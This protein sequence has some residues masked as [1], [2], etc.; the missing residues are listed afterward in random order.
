MKRNVMVILFVCLYAL[1]FPLT[2][3]AEE[4]KSEDKEKKD[5]FEIPSHVL[6]ISKENTYPNSTED[7]EVIEPSE[8]T[9][10][11]IEEMKVPIK[12]PDLIKMLNETTLKPSPIAIGY[13]G[14]VY[15]GRWPLNYESLETNINWEY[16]KINTNELNN[17]GGEQNQEMRYIQQDKK[18]IKGALTNKINN[19]D[20][21][22]KMMLLEA[23]DKTKL[24]LSYNTVI[25]K[26]TKK[27]NSYN[28][29]TEKY[30]TLQAYAPA[31]NEKG[32]V[33]FGEVYIEL[34]GGKKAIVIKNVTK[35][36]IGGWIP[37]QDHVSFSLSVK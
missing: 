20:D 6:D 22:K 31:V 19:P 37:I 32:R 30:G 15:L 16:Q 7:Q 1:V 24:P 3:F 10:E 2:S 33:T 25:G 14:M 4:E 36:G 18:E 21:V 9:K 23:K 17:I 29:P 26:N 27:D 11:L 8:L 5:P 12:N 34:K 28:I 35:Q 13:R